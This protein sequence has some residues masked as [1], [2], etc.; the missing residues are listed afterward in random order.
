MLYDNAKTE[1]SKP[2]C[3]VKVLKLSENIRKIFGFSCQKM[4]GLGQARAQV[5]KIWG[6]RAP[7]ANRSLRLC[8]RRQQLTV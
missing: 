3:R 7:W 5:A 4:G 2:F 8:I 1:D 6:A